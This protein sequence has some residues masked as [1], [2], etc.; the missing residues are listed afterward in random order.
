MDGQQ[1]VPASSHHELQ[2]P[3]L[4][5]MGGTSQNLSLT[6]PRKAFLSPHSKESYSHFCTCMGET[7]Q[8]LC[9][10]RVAKMRNTLSLPIARVG[11]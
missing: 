1:W 7:G 6:E 9:A 10:K 4:N 8:S 5:A 3:Q 11:P 2:T